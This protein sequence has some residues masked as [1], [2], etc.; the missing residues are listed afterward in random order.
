[1]S[2][3][4]RFFNKA[5]QNIKE[6]AYETKCAVIKGCKWL[7][8]EEGKVFITG[9]EVGICVGAA[10]VRRQ[11]ANALGLSTKELVQ[12]VKDYRKNK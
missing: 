1:M 10:L 9:I 11:D 3:I 7:G 5:K 4:D 2:K 12:K 6:F 8:T